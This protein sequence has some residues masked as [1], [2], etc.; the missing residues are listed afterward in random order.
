MDLLR[1]EKSIGTLGGGNHFIEVDRDDEG[2]LYVVGVHV[3]HL[4]FELGDGEGLL[5]LRPAHEPSRPVG[6]GQKELKRLKNLKRTAIPRQ[7][8]YVE[9]TLF[10]QYIHDMKLVQR[11]AELNRQAMI[12]QGANAFFRPEQV[13]MAGAAQL[14]Q[15]DLVQVTGQILPGGGL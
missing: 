9:G 3:R 13:H 5:G 2:Q 11:F 15:V 7:L 4:L 8:A 10:D 14:L 1:A 12:A 6:R